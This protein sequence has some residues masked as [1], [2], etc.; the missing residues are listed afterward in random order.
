MPRV[1]RAVLE[2]DGAGRRPGPGA[3]GLTVA[4]NVTDWPNTDGLATSS[5]G[6][7]SVLAWLTTWVS[8]GEVLVV[9]LVS[10][11]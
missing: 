2:G 6:P 5:T 11:P 7:W 10:P 4:V 9:K 8:A 3:A 1:V